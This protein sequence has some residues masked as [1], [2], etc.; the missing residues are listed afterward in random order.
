MM[1]EFSMY[2]V[3]T[4]VEEEEKEEEE[5]SR[6]TL[7]RLLRDGAERAWAFPSASMPPWAETKTETQVN[8]LQ[9]VSEFSMSNAKTKAEKEEKEEEFY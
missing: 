7:G 3:K 2:N 6:A 4:K 1:S 5:V 8:A 9:M